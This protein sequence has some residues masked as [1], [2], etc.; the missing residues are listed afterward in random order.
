VGRERRRR[1]LTRLAL[2]GLTAGYV[3][4]AMTLRR[5]GLQLEV[6]APPV[7]GDRAGERPAPAEV[8]A[9]AGVEV[10]DATR[11][12]IA[13]DMAATGALAVDLVP[14]DLPAERAFRLLRRVEPGRFAVDPLYAPGGAHEALALDASLAGR[15]V[16]APAAPSG[17][18]ALA[19]LTVRAQRHAPHRAALRVVR[20]LHAV[21]QRPVDR[22]RELEQL[23]AFGRPLYALTPLLVGARAAHLA[24][25]AAAVVAAPLAGLVAVVAW[26]VQP[27]LAVGWTRGSGRL[28]PPGLGRACM[29]RWPRAWADVLRVAR[30]G[31]VESRR[32]R[33][34]AAEAMP[35]PAPDLADRFDA[36]RDTCPWCGATA[37]VGRLDT[38]DLFQHK[39]GEFHLDR[40]TACGHIFQ[41]PALSLA[42]LDYYYDQFYDGVSDE[43]TEVSF[44]AMARIYRRRTDV[45][46]RFT[47]PRAC[48]DVGTGHAH[49]CLIAR[50]RWPDAVVD[51]LDLSDSV[52]E[53]ARRGWI[54]TGYRGAFPDLAGGLPRSYDTVTMHHYLEHTRQPRAELAAAAK[55]LEPGGHLV[56]EVPD[57]ASPWARR[58]G[59]FW[60]SWFQPQHQHFV[61]CDNLVAALED[62]G[63]DVVSVERGPA[64]L[65]GDLFTAV[66]L[67]MQT[68]APSP[69]EPW[70]PA[71]T[72]RRRAR[73]LAVLVVAAPL[74]VVAALPD[75]ILDVRLRRPG[76]T[77]PGNALRVVARRS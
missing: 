72:R 31:A 43:L 70:L 36:P 21:P 26:S 38:V 8:L 77:K 48:L 1:R 45:I 44:A 51:G 54:D 28:A 16:P 39:P 13:R 12:S 2:L 29:A 50:Q 59:R 69:H 14:D 76:T 27:A 37:L 34:S 35:T 61:T 74:L 71:P 5:R 22:W 63:F 75:L 23:T 42:G 68:V 40:C 33:R 66:V 60:Y 30:V 6:L 10:D 58:L 9:L 7:P 62:E 55:V 15:M 67:A 47:E 65:G 24:V 46:A 49:F 73:R 41:N 64:N 17:R 32:A 20:G 18:A 52:D 57:A 3:A 56:I 19:Q 53:A 4:E 11:S 25:L